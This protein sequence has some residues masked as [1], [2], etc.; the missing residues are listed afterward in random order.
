VPVLKNLGTVM[1]QKDITP[2]E[3]AGQ[4]GREFSNSTVRRALKGTGVD[5][6][7]AKAIAKALKVK[8]EVLCES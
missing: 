2:E 1:K 4:S 8:L 5:L 6:L 3:L 7:K